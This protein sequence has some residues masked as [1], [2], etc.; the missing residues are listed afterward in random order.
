MIICSNHRDEEELYEVPLIYTYAWD[1]NEYWCPYC[2]CHEGMLSAGVDV[3]ETE[4][5]KKRL[6]SYKEA[7]KEF[8]NARCTLICIETK[9]KG[10]YIKP[11]EL[12]IKERERLQKLTETWKYKIKIEDLLSK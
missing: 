8:L 6:E 9:W 5:L 11:S 3:K 12:P 2:G 1:H 4:E 7:S 10:K